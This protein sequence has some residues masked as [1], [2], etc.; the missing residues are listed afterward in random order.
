MNPLSQEFLEAL[1]QNKVKDAPT[2]CVIFFTAKWCGPCN[3][4]PLD[5]LVAVSDKLTWFL[6][7]VDENQ[8]SPGFCGVSGIPAMLGIV[9]GKPT[10]LFQAGNPQATAQWLMQVASS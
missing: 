1:L 4:L 3:N 9:R 7:D 10:K 8:F 2:H 5:K 6:C